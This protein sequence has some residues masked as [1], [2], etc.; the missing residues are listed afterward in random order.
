[1]TQRTQLFSEISRNK[2]KGKTATA[3][4]TIPFVPFGPSVQGD[5]DETRPYHL[6][7]AISSVFRHRIPPLCGIQ[8]QPPLDAYV[9]CFQLTD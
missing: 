5:L 8:R 6:P 7:T 9:V 3:I 4:A 1:M 2:A